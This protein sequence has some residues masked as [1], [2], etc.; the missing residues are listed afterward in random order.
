MTLDFSEEECMVRDVVQRIVETHIRPRAV[1]LDEEESF[2]WPQIKVLADN[3]LM[4][5]LVPQKY[6][7]QQGSHLLYAMVVEEIARACAATALVY[8]TNTHGQLPILLAGTDTQKVHYLPPMANGEWLGALAVTEPQNGSDAAHMQCRATR[9]SDGYVLNGEKIFIT[10]GDKADVMVVFARTGEP[11]AR[12]ISAF[13]V[14]R[15]NGV[16]T[17]RVERKMGV[18]GSSTAAL[19]FEDVFVPTVQ[20]LGEEHQGFSTLMRTFD[21]TRLSTAAQAVGIAQG[22]YDIALE[23][24][25]V[26]QQFG[27]RIFDFQGMQFRLS[28]MLADITAGRALLYQTARL[29]DT[30][31]PFTMEAAMA[32]LWCSEMAGRVTNQ[33]VQALGGY[34]YMREF[35]VERMMRD[36]KITQIYDGTSDIQKLV[37]AR[38]VL[39]VVQ[40]RRGAQ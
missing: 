36:A 9:V 26:R 17:S 16:V 8:F 23:Y 3:G 27:R 35:G 7:G 32:K 11:G 1:E 14:E 39:D 4:G 24:T 30:G 31:K 28:E 2:P 21:T 38:R 37:I 18:R 6:G 5:I 33:A 40:G 15:K 34:G 20:R 12:G 22:A 19:R 29:V 25:L 10:N 13:I